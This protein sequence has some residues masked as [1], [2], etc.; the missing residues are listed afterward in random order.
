MHSTEPHVAEVLQTVGGHRTRASLDGFRVVLVPFTHSSIGDSMVTR[1]ARGPRVARPAR[2]DTVETKMLTATAT[3]AQMSNNYN[4]HMDWGNGSTWVMVVIMVVVTVAIVGGIIW[5]IVFSSRSANHPG[6]IAG[7][8][9]PTAAGPPRPALRPRRD[10]DRGLQRTP[11][12]T[13]L[14]PHQEPTALARSSTVWPE[15]R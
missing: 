14:K 10:R 12:R 13:R 11:F 1:N 5:A 7:P 8:T 6:P 4:D 2:H 9:G 3:L 15:T